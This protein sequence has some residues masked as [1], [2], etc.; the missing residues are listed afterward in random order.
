MWV[1]GEFPSQK[2]VK[3]SF[4]ISFDLHQNKWFIKQ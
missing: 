4:D 3:Q 2:P 1:T